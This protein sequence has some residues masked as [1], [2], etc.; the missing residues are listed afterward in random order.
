VDRHNQPGL[1]LFDTS[2][3]SLCAAMRSKPAHDLG[4]DV[5]VVDGPRYLYSELVPRVVG[6]P[7]LMLVPPRLVRAAQRYGDL[8][9]TFEKMTGEINKAPT[10]TARLADLD[11]PNPPLTFDA[12]D[13]LPWRSCVELR[14]L[15]SEILH[16]LRVAADHL[17][18]NVA[19][20]DS[21]TEQ[22][23][24]QF[25][26]YAKR[27]DFRSHGLRMLPG[28]NAT[29]R[30]WIEAVQP[31]NGVNWTASL[32]YLSNNDKHNYLHEVVP[33]LSYRIDLHAA[34]PHEADP[35]VVSLPVDDLATHVRLIRRNGGPYREVDAE[36]G[37]IISGLADLVNQFLREAGI[38][39]VKLE[40]N[41]P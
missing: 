15:V 35:E 25:P 33:T 5:P 28:V 12:E 39:E 10:M 29:H 16:H 17:I 31:Y 9:A 32:A 8:L 2:S 19:W 3:A 23:R 34:V 18:Y 22:K 20:I 38:S 27:S 36:I 4:K 24:T 37:D 30:G 7:S 11:K 41:K 21:G 14:M 26:V 13:V 6:D 1:E 40:R